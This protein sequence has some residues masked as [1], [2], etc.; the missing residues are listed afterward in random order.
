MSDHNPSTRP[1]SHAKRPPHTGGGEGDTLDLS[2]RGAPRDGVPQTLD[3]RLFMQLQ[4]FRAPQ[5]SDPADSV[6]ALGRALD[7]R[8]VAGVVYED[9][10]D[11]R[12]L[13]LLSWSEDPVHFVDAVR[14][15][16]RRDVLRDLDARPEMT[17]FG[18]SYST[19]YEPDLQFFLLDRPRQTALNAEWP[20]AVWY[21]LRRKGAFNRLEGREQGRILREHG[22]IGRAYGE[23][24]FA[25]DIRL[26]CHGLDFVIGLIGKELH[27]LSHVVQRMRRTEQTALHMEQMG[28]FFVGRAVHHSAGRDK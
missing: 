1:P 28:P 4:V 22:T 13:G 23:Q 27:P 9:A 14:P 24:D 15:L 21:P 12:G 26:A 7:D 20:W 10:Q 19:G 16:F 6:T 3:R 11:H 18:R 8:G 25:H 17:M 5:G 2:E